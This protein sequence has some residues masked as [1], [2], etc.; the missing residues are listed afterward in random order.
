MPT[1]FHNEL[2]PGVVVSIEG[3]GGWKQ[4]GNG[5]TP[6]PS[7]GIT[8]RHS[9]LRRRGFDSQELAGEICTRKC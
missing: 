6:P 8:R 2:F 3:A 4:T 9:E 1:I 5:A 7:A